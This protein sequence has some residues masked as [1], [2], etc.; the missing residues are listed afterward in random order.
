M[1]LRSL[2]LA[3]WAFEGWK[4]P[5]FTYFVWCHW[6]LM[7]QMSVFS[8]S[9]A[10]PSAVWGMAASA[11]SRSFVRDAGYWVPPKTYWIRICFFFFLFRATPAAYWSSQATSRLGEQLL[12]SITATAMPCPTYTTAHGNARALTHWARPGIEPVSSGTLVRFVT[13][14]ATM[15]IPEAVYD[16]INSKRF[17]VR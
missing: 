8:K 14:W 17:G 2:S 6:Y 11:S 10:I 13:C 3:H 12:A 15:G 7:Q 4:L 5:C 16:L 1:L 9:R